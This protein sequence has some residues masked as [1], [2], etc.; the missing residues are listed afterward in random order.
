MDNFS[1]S[2]YMDKRIW[3]TRVGFYTLSGSP[4]VPKIAVKLTAVYW[5]QVLLGRA[6]IAAS[7]SDRRSCLSAF[8][9]QNN[10]EVALESRWPLGFILAEL[11]YEHVDAKGITWRCF[12]IDLTEAFY[13]I[14]RSLVTGEPADDE[15]IMHV[16]RRMGLSEDLMK[17]LYAHLA[18]PA[19]IEA[20][21]FTT[22]H[23]EHHQSLACGYLLQ[24]QRARGRVP[25][26]TRV[27]PGWLLRRCHLFVPVE[28][29]SPQ[30][31]SCI[32]G[33]TLWGANSSRAWATSWRR[34][35]GGRFSTEGIFW[36]RRGWTT[37]AFA[38]LI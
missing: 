10:W 36:V 24:S 35:H 21:G 28:P 15:L 30:F 8:F 20:A 26:G 33:T 29:Y 5:C 13:R 12:F 1:S 38:Y 32:G 31:P 27:T 25:Y 37:R 16:G 4:K 19:A 9:K 2:Q 3:P 34:S 6:C 22:A 18:E 7:G 11:L 17:D 23:A 14:L